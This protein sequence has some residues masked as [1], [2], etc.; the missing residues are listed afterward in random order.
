MRS[1]ALLSPCVRRRPQHPLTAGIHNNACVVAAT[2]TQQ[3]AAASIAT[4]YGLPLRAEAPTAG[5]ALLVDT[6]HISLVDTSRAVVATPFVLDLDAVVRSRSR[7]GS[8][9]DVLRAVGR[10]PSDSSTAYVL[11]ATAGAGFD[12]AVLA[13]GGWRVV[14]AE[15]HPVWAC[16]L[17]DAV[18]RS[19][20]RPRMTVVWTD[21]VHWMRQCP[22]AHR[23]HV[24]YADPMYTPGASRGSAKS[25]KHAQL[26]Q[27]LCGCDDSDVCALVEAARACAVTRVVLKRPVGAP[28][29]AS[30]ARR[31]LGNTTRFDLYTPS[32]GGD[33]V[34]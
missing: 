24:V 22:A 16:L 34:L 21:A 30:P 11:D 31:L 25:K 23:P 6:A 12:G 5:F 1:L 18:R 7:D 27:A 4:Q 9:P 26:L 19:H 3:A 28:V 29:V 8:V 14:L 20:L 32:H 10:P 17:A 13:A 33:S 2:P 15:R